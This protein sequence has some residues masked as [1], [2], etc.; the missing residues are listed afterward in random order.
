KPKLGFLVAKDVSNSFQWKMNPRGRDN[1]PRMAGLFNLLA[2]FEVAGSIFAQK[3]GEKLNEGRIQ[4]LVRDARKTHARE[5][6]ATSRDNEQDE[7]VID[8]PTGPH[9]QDND[10]IT[11]K[12]HIDRLQILMNNFTL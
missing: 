2:V 10:G 11:L 5:F 3:K 8:A 7:V 6:R 12:Q 1:R 4:Q 9:I